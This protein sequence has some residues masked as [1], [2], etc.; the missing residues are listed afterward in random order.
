MRRIFGP[1]VALFGILILV[2]LV[3]GAAYSAGLGAAGVVVTP[4][5]GAAAG[6]VVA[7]PWYGGFGFGFGHLFGFLLFVFLFFALIRLAFGGGHRRRGGWG[8]GWGGYYG[9]GHDHGHGPMGGRG[10]G[11]GPGSGPDD[12]AHGVDPREAWIRGRLDDWHRTAHTSGVP[13]Q[14]GPTASGGSDPATTPG[15]TPPT[16][17]PAAG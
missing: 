6:T 7:Y 13:G 14:P 8:G 9:Q 1:I 5:A 12:P 16:D 2:G 17:R 11:S 3:A 15:A 10:P 4:A